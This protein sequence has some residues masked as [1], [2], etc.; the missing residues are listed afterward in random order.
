MD[1]TRTWPQCAA[2]QS[3]LHCG[4]WWPRWRLEGL[5]S[6]VCVCNYTHRKAHKL[7]IMTEKYKMTNA[8]THTNAR[9]RKHSY[10]YKHAAECGSQTAS[11]NRSLNRSSIREGNKKYSVHTDTEAHTHTHRVMLCW[12]WDWQWFCR[13]QGKNPMRLCINV[14]VCPSET[15]PALTEQWGTWV[16]GQRTRGEWQGHYSQSVKA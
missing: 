4:R 15:N 2:E 14:C 11:W 12:S 3:E 9:M 1:S 5:T 6:I 10:A 7:G 13:P 8:C 16:R